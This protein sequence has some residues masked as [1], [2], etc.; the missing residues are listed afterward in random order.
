MTGFVWLGTGLAFAI[1]VVVG[2][3]FLVVWFK[4]ATNLWE[5]A[6]DLWEGTEGLL[7]AVLLTFLAFT[8]IQAEELTKKW[9]KRLRK[10][11]DVTPSPGDDVDA[12]SVSS[13]ASNQSMSARAF[14]WLKTKFGG[15]KEAAVEAK[16]SSVV[17]LADGTID[18]QEKE[19][20]NDEPI[21][22]SGTSGYSMFIL[23][24][25]TVLREGLECFVFIGG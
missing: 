13:T 4:Y 3:A 15:K 22:K 6:E 10:H 12:A 5:T 21:I 24:F 11:F 20:A 7:A 2:A 9:H 18:K 8:F 1:S 14:E 19:K 16:D 25:V 17:T 23:P